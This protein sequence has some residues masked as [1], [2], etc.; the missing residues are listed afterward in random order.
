MNFLG[1]LNFQA[2]Y[3]PWVLLG[4]SL[5]LGN[6]IAVDLMGLM[7]YFSH[8]HFNYFNISVYL[9]LLKSDFKVFD[10]AENNFKYVFHKLQFLSKNIYNIK[11]AYEFDIWVSSCSLKPLGIGAK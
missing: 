8:R 5:L 11:L 1:L 10:F 7:L 2:P 6:S 4:F 3:L 9:F